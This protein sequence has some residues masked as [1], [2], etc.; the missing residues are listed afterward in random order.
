MA[1]SMSSERAFSLAGITVSKR[2]NRL[3]GDVVKALQF[4]K[5][6]FKSNLIFCGAAEEDLEEEIID[7][8]G[9]ADTAEA[10]SDI[11]QSDTEM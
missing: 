8:D 4:L 9:S 11:C 1:S 2:R 3:Q 10:E 5:W 7:C 6:A